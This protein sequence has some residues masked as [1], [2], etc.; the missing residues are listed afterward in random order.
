[1]PVIRDDLTQAASILK[2]VISASDCDDCRSYDLAPAMR[3]AV[4]LL[5]AVHDD[6]R[7]PDPSRMKLLEAA[8]IVKACIVADTTAHGAGDLSWP[9]LPA[10]RLIDEVIG[11]RPTRPRTRPRSA[12]KNVVRL[13]V[14]STP[15]NPG[16]VDG[17]RSR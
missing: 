11:R 5:D 7:L 10:V 13:R 8:G 14:V 1:M 6:D 3:A 16:A 12:R 15:T 2:A 4:T 17:P 9:L